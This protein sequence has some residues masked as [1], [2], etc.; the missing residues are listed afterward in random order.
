MLLPGP[1]W[2]PGW[3]ELISFHVLLVFITKDCAGRI[4]SRSL[5]LFSGFPLIG[6]CW[7]CL[8]QLAV[9][10]SRG[11][12]VS[13]ERQLPDQHKGGSGCESALTLNNTQVGRVLLFLHSPV[14]R[15]CDVMSGE[16]TASSPGDASWNVSSSIDSDSD[17]DLSFPISIKRSILQL[18]AKNQ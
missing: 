12:S 5:K 1:L 4:H 7:L 8:L 3:Q 14:G 2:S 11:L 9:S 10:Q 17:L 13:P 6:S 18:L 16:N 15:Q